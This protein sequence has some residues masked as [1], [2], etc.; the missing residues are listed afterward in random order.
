MSGEGE[1]KEPANSHEIQKIGFNESVVLGSRTMHV[2]TEVLVRDGVFV[3]TTAVE[4]G[5]V[6]FVDTVPCPDCQT[7]GEIEEFAVSQHRRSVE[8]VRRDAKG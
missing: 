1:G 4:G 8:R 2:Q 5:F 3:R 6:H 7:L